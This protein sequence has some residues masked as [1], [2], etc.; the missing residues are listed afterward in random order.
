[1][2][3]TAHRRRRLTAAAAVVGALSLATGCAAPAEQEQPGA[4]TASA[5]PSAAFAG[6][7]SKLATACPTLTGE[8][9]IRLKK[10]APGTPSP[11]DAVTPIAQNVNCTWGEGEGS[12][13][14]SL[15]IN[16]TDGPLPADQAM[17]QQF[18]ATFDG[19]TTDG[20][21]LR[22]RAEPGVEDK[23]YMAIHKDRATIE[24][25]VLSSNASV[26]VYYQGPEMDESQWDAA[27]R[28]RQTDLRGLAADVLD[29]LS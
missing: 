19:Y 1:M 20:T 26:T 15:Q 8:A 21:I 11:A 6:K 16:L 9:A 24:L 28:E 14:V 2:R 25:W 29:D 5:S 4:P 18:Q 12:V 27:L 13:G 22:W 23:A 17:A 7:W 10:T 3:A